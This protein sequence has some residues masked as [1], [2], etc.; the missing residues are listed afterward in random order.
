[1]DVPVPV[2]PKQDQAQ[3]LANVLNAIDGLNVSLPVGVL[4]QLRQGVE[5]VLS[6]LASELKAPQPSSTPNS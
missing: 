3:T 6:S 2:L 5:I 4:L 1:M